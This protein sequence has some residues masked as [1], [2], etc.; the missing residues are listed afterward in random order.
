[1]RTLIVVAH[2]D[3]E[4]LGAAS[5]LAADPMNTWVLHC[6]DSAP[7]NLDYARRAGFQT[8]EDY[9]AAR[10]EEFRNAMSVAG[11]PETNHLRLEI[12]DQEAT[13][14]V[15]EIIAA[16]TEIERDHGIE[17][18]LTHAY[19]GGHPDHDAIA[20]A[21]Q[22][23]KVANVWEM[24]LYHAYGGDF[25][26]RTPLPHP[27]AAAAAVIELTP[28]QQAMKSAM[29]DCFV[30][31]HQVVSRFPGD[32]EVFRPMPLYDFTH[33]PHE[34]SLYYDGRPLVWQ[35]KEWRLYI[36]RTL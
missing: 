6:T 22:T 15:S 7:L 2:T 16:I 34:G 20:F 14:R 23:A 32:R 17:R 27:A 29:L 28:E 25:V 36:T 30:T 8:R 33:P 1:M 18:I 3:D 11:V 19:E 31:Q 35:S 4:T 5:V 26:T 10:R 21:V 9:A 13:R 12:P 24:P